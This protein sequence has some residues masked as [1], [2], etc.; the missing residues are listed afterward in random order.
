MGNKDYRMDF[1]NIFGFFKECNFNFRLKNFCFFYP[2]YIYLC[3]G[4]V[5]FIL[6]T[7][8]FCKNLKEEYLENTFLDKNKVMLSDNFNQKDAEYKLQ[9]FGVYTLWFLA[10]VFLGFSGLNIEK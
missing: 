5:D 2:N 8:A 7:V 1:L 6:G 4:N 3:L 10:L 9:Y